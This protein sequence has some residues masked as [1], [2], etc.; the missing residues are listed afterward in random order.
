MHNVAQA[1]NVNAQDDAR[2][3]QSETLLHEV[4][5]MARHQKGAAPTTT[6]KG[7]ADLP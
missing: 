3:G 7:Q 4:F 6:L 5:T 1:T 2:I